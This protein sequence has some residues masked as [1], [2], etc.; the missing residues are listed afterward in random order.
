MRLVMPI[1]RTIPIRLTGDIIARLDRLA[2]ASGLTR[3]AVMRICISSFTE[4]VGSSLTS[5]QLGALREK[6]RELD[7]RT[8]RY[9]GKRGI[10]ENEFAL[11][12]YQH[13]KKPDGE[14]A[15]GHPQ[16]IDPVFKRSKGRRIDRKKM[17]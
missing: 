14:I 5:N 2:K 9:S 17:C 16:N 4:V 8:Y 10:E 6:L 15:A 1:A 3:T 11:Q 13:A 12:A 7:G